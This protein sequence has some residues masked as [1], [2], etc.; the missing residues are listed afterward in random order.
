MNSN[1]PDIDSGTFLTQT[2]SAGSGTSVSV[3]DARYFTNGMGMISGDTIMI[4]ANTVMI[5]AVD[6]TNNILTIDRSINWNSGDEVSYPCNGASPN[7][8]AF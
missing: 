7:K 8:G 5:T 2:S 3:K 1:S 4:D 6:Y